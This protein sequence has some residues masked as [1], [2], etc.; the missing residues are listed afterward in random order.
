MAIPASGVFVNLELLLQQLAYE[1]AERTLQEGQAV[2]DD[3]TL[4]D[5]VN[6]IRLCCS[7]M[8]VRVRGSNLKLRVCRVMD[9]RAKL[10]FYQLPTVTCCLDCR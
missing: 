8:I 4:C 6:I 1:V 10:H 3:K 5:I 9:A 7:W 2:E